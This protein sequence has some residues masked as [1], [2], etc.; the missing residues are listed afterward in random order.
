MK[1]LIFLLLLTS[2][3]FA[4]KQQAPTEEP[5]PQMTPELPVGQG[6]SPLQGY[7]QGFPQGMPQPQQSEGFPQR[8]ARSPV[9][10]MAGGNFSCPF[11]NETATYT[12]LRND[13]RSA[14]TQLR[15]LQEQCRQATGVA[16]GQQAASA[17][18]DRDI[19]DLSSPVSSDCVQAEE[20]VQGRVQNI[21]YLTQEY[22]LPE[23]PSSGPRRIRNG[24]QV[25]DLYGEFR[26]CIRTSFQDNTAEVDLDCVDAAARLQI[27][28]AQETGSI[29]GRQI[30][31]QISEEASQA[32]ARAMN[33]FEALMN[34]P[35]C[36]AGAPVGAS[37]LNLGVGLAMSNPISGTVGLIARFAQNFLGGLFGRRYRGAEDAMRTIEGDETRRSIQCLFMNMHKETL[38]CG[39]QDASRNREE[40]N[41]RLATARAEL[42][43][44]QGQI[45]ANNPGLRPEEVITSCAPGSQQRSPESVLASTT[46]IAQTFAPVEE[47]LLAEATDINQVLSAFLPVCQAYR[48]QRSNLTDIP[49]LEPHLQKLDA[50]CAS[51]TPPSL[52]DFQ[53]A[54]IGPDGA[55][56]TLQL[57]FAG[58]SLNPAILNRAPASDPRTC[59]RERGG[60]LLLQYQEKSGQVRSLERQIANIPSADDSG[61]GNSAMAELFRSF[62]EPLLRDNGTNL[63]LDQS[64]DRTWSAIREYCAGG[65]PSG[66]FRSYINELHATCLLNASA[67]LYDHESRTPNFTNRNRNAANWENSCKTHFLNNV[68]RAPALNGGA[69]SINPAPDARSYETWQCQAYTNF[70]RYKLALPANDNELFS[71][72][73][74]STG[75]SSSGDRSSRRGRRE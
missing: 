63:R 58:R 51:S 68:D 3:S 52:A 23:Q 6:G 40:L 72:F 36:S 60:D 64:L 4:Q 13:A 50:L 73:C 48:P 32:I 31:G 15:T 74:G 30:C 47:A 19:T 8:S 67:Y 35:Q 17:Q 44:I 1:L 14:L 24:S 57:Q 38:A 65:S 49:P 45:Q 18:L 10:S 61:R 9:D 12:S 39:A 53:S 25:R 75:Q 26:E 28:R 43:S 42:Q 16:A 69:I 41:Q 22:G 2:Q 59:V 71:E 5:M 11:K 70:E 54:L 33:T 7:P 55:K 27:A 20:I 34:N 66:Q 21:Q 62:K 37:L 56:T 46:A 29:G